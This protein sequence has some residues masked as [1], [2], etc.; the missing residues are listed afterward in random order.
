MNHRHLHV[1]RTEKKCKQ[2][3]KRY[4]PIGYIYEYII[5]WL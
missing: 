2:Q 5:Q 1:Y 3:I 4:L